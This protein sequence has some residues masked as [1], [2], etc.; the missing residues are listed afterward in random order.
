M[1]KNVHQRKA[2][3]KCR[4]KREG[5]NKRKGEKIRCVFYD[6][7]CYVFLSFSPF[8]PALL[9]FP[10]ER[11]RRKGK[12]KKKKGEKKKQER[13][14]KRILLT[15]RKSILLSPLFVLFIVFKRS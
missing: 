11:K 12:R 4:E 3:K 5:E 7:V 10:A 15:Y 1:H 8:N 13:R 6:L 14:G 2:T 9:F